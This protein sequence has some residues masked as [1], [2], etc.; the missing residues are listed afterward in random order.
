MNRLIKDNLSQLKTIF[1]THKVERAYVFGSGATENLNDESDIDFLISFDKEIEP[2]EKG[3]LW[4]SLY[5][6]LKTVFKREV[7]L[8]TE[9]S[10]K[11]PYFIKEV[12]STRELV[13][14]Q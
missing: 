13:Y 8:L 6:A 4:W 14:G 11:N 12:L 5:D 9:N 7:D 3:E 10:L 1:Q 2:L